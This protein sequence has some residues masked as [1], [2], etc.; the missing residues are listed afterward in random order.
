VAQLG[1]DEGAAWAK[2][3]GYRRFSE[4]GKKKT[5]RTTLKISRKK[6]A[7]GTNF[8]CVMPR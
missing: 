3:A 2:E 6:R 7:K 8:E 5:K 1:Y 4:G